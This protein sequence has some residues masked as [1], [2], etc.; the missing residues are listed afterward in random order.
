[1][2]CISPG[3]VQYLFTILSYFSHTHWHNRRSGVSAMDSVVAVV[4]GEL[5]L[6]GGAAE[7]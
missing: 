1:V 4:V 2:H 3:T 5:V 7:D 6:S